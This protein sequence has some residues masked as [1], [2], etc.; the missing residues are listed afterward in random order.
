MTWS[1]KLNIMKQLLFLFAILPIVLPVWS[2]TDNNSE[3]ALA[4]LA[5]IEKETRSFLVGEYEDWKNC[6][7]HSD[8]IYFEWVRSN[9]HHFYTSWADLD[10]TMRPII[11]ENVG[12]GDMFY[13]QRSDLKIMQNGPVAWV[14]YRQNLSGDM[15]HEQR[16]LQ[17]IDG[18]WKI[19]MVTVVASETFPKFEVS[20]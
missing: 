15:S 4:I 6:W 12:N 14:T 7:V 19:S 11:T 16:I 10:R 9:V 2:Q 18:E 20:K 3:E 5:V 1:I 13:S 17:K 8:D